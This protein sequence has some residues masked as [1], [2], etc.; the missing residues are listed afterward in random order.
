MQVT[1]WRVP[2]LAIVSFGLGAAGFAVAKGGDAAKEL[3]IVPSGEAKFAPATPDPNGPQAAIVS[4]DPKTGP[5]A[6]FLKTKGKAPTHWHTSDYWVVNLKGEVKH[7]LPGKDADAKVLKEGSFWFQPGGSDKTAHNDEC[8]TKDGCLSFLVMTGKLDF[9]P[10]KD[11][12]AK[13]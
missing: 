8:V 3:V 4:G 1:G 7:W 9:F 13:K 6:F 10:V 11:S 12:G 2:L 5:V